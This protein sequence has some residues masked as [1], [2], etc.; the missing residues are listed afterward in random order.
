MNNLSIEISSRVS[1]N[2]E[3][4]EITFEGNLSVQNY[5][6]I[7]N[8]LFTTFKNY[9][10]IKIVLQNITDIDLEVFSLFYKY[11][12]DVNV[13][14]QIIGSYKS[15]LSDNIINNISKTKILLPIHTTIF[16]N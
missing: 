15:H 1:N 6:M 16:K 2:P 7:H 9:K 13:E 12:K 14:S 8:K 4:V 3:S 10:Y 11:K 5:S